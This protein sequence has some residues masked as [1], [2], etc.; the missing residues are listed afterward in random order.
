[1]TDDPLVGRDCSGWVLERKIGQGGMGSVY[2]ARRP[3]DG[4][5][6]VVKFLAEEQAQNPT[7]RGR[8]L[9][10]A[11][12][13]EQVQHENIVGVH[14]VVE[15]DV[16]YIVMEFVDG[17]GLDDLLL[18]RGALPHPDA[19]RIVRD[20]ARGL[21]HAHKSN[22]IHRD[23]KPANV[24]LTREGVVKVLDFGLAKS[25]T[26]DDGLS[27]AGQVLGTP[28]YMAP[29][30]WGDHQVDAR[31]DVFALGATL[32]QLL[33]N[34]LPFQGTT[35]QQISNRAKKGDFT[36]P[37]ALVPALPEDL[38][39]VVLR[40]L[41]PDRTFRYQ[42]AQVLAEDLQ[43]LLDGR[44]VEVTCLL[45]P[46][47]ARH[48]L[49][50]ETERVVGSGAEA[51]VVLAGPSIAPR[52]ATLSRSALGWVVRDL[53]SPQG[54]FVG[55]V[56][57]TKDVLLKEGD[58]VRFGDVTCRFKDGGLAAQLHAGAAVTA[59]V[60]VP[61]YL[62]DALL[63][64]ADR[65]CVLA[66]IEDLDRR[67][68][69]LKL[70]ATR[71]ELTP[72]YGEETAEAV[73]A[74]LEKAQRRALSRIPPTL[75]S[76]THENLGEDIAAWLAWWEQ[77]QANYPPQA[78]ASLPVGDAALRITKGE[79]QVRDVLL[80][81]DVQTF[82]IGRDASCAVVVG[83]RSVSRLHAT[84]HRLHRRLMIR[85][86]GSRLGTFLNGERVHS[87]LLDSGDTIGVGKAE[88]VFGGAPPVAA[89][90]SDD[91]QDGTV[92][93]DPE[94]YL[95]LESLRHPATVLASLRLIEL[96]GDQEL[97]AGAVGSLF[98]GE[99]EQARCAEALGK[100]LD[101][102]AAEAQKLLGAVLGP[103]PGDRWAA[104]WEARSGELPTQAIPL[105]W[106]G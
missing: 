25:V 48:A 53:G 62:F 26:T 10:E 97:I 90:P 42:S 4:A 3:G 6:V 45:G 12:V 15:A 49:L 8:F 85:D 41:V 43:R 69:Q 24:L 16:P 46:D 33:T 102:R 89:L 80:P 84:L 59:S 47:G 57:T 101:K 17:S 19:V 99:A 40:A 60:A 92:W 29:E 78:V 103:D 35:P 28:H 51:H 50:L 1:M 27:M 75:F 23:I 65:R 88:L 68:H 67:P 37:R 52:H 2:L 5:R 31:A 81:A 32:Y 34:T 71:A 36:R 73:A 86:G 63:R 105:G 18:K 70:E 106:F 20:I 54:T 95:A 38:E 22:V 94:V 82:T 87:A 104:A 44:P 83:E 61:S 11:R 7:W 30:Q 21:A 64:L 77:V 72:W 98:T 93:V 96:A 76:I 56:R 79:P 14:A 55:G 58:E 9:R 100:V 66:L 91:P 74:A 13:M 39:L